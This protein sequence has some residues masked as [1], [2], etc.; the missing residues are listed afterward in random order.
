MFKQIKNTGVLC[1]TF[2]LGI[3]LKLSDIYTLLKNPAQNQL[4]LLAD[5]SWSKMVLDGHAI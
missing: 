5:F 2:L 4:L 1:D 3:N